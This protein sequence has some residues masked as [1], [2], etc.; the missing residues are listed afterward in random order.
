MRTWIVVAVVAVLVGLPAWAAAQEAD[1]L[2]REIE[3]M[4]QQMQNAQRE[5]Q[6]TLDALTERLQRLEARPQQAAMPPIV[7]QAPPGP[8]PPTLT[9]LA[10]PRQPFTLY[11]ERRQGQFLL[12]FG[13]VGDFVGN[14]TQRNVEKATG[15]TFAGRENRGLAA[16]LAGGRLLERTPERLR[17]AAPSRF[18]AERLAD[19]RE[20][21]EAV[22]ARLFGHTLGVEIE[23]SSDAPAP[24]ARSED[25]EAARRLRERALEHAAVNTALEVL[26]AKIVD[27]R[28]AP[29]PGG[30]RGS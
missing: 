9:D 3:Q 24:I 16:A 2:R 23:T 1:T 30:P 11:G 20:A 26:E 7:V 25:R 5:Y 28:P 12:D 17:I 18:A 13:V 21:L 29:G 4:R 22:C 19:R 14:I 8:A 10:K 6:K 27:I 15:G